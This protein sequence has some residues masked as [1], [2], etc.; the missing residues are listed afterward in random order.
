MLRWIVLKSKMETKKQAGENIIKDSIFVYSREQYDIYMAIYKR[1]DK[2]NNTSFTNQTLC[3]VTPL[4][5]TAWVTQI[6]IIAFNVPAGAETAKD[7]L[8]W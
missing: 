7:F 6:I 2:T 8:S 4:S 3:N 5:P 1:P